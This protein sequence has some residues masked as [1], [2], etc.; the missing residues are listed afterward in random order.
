MK[1]NKRNAALFLSDILE[2]IVTIE[3]YI[4]NMTF[5]EFMQDKKTRDAVSRNI[6]IVGEAARNLPV[7]IRTATPH[8][9]WDKMIRSRHILS[10]E[11]F[12]ID[13]EIIWRIAIVHLPETKD[14]ITILLTETQQQ[15]YL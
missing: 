7:A 14:S 11:Y 9:P 12:G 3:E 15:S 4:Q 5:E 13:Y 2:A 10:H 8:I 6:E 1:S